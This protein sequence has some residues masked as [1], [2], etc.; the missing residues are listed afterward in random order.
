MRE[1]SNIYSY[2]T[3]IWRCLEVTAKN[4]NTVQSVAKFNDCL[5]LSYFLSCR[6]KNEQPDFQMIDARSSLISKWRYAENKNMMWIK[7]QKQA[8]IDEALINKLIEYLDTNVEYDPDNNL[9]EVDRRYVIGC[10]GTVSE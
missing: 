5:A 4:P 1:V 3:M 2:K 7:L 10:F 6:L 9:I 8:N